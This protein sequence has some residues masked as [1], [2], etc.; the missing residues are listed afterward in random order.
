MLNLMARLQALRL[1]VAAQIVASGLGSAALIVASLAIGIAAVPLIAT[2][3][4]WIAAMALL[5]GLFC[6]A[7]GRTGSDVRWR[8]LSAAFDLIVLAGVPF[9]FALADPSR[10]LAASFVLF[11]I[12]AAVAASLFA[13]VTRKLNAADCGI[14]ILAFLLACA[15]PPWF[16]LIAY[17]MG[18]AAFIAAGMRVS[19][20]LT[21]SDG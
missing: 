4:S 3:H 13:D 14:C 5:G 2:Q 19:L 15:M 12:V 6:A 21:R 20:A 11:G 7:V 10:A 8:D 9:G 18:L 1:Q 17:V 16:S